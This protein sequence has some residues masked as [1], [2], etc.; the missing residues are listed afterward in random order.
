M[1]LAEWIEF[2]ANRIVR[3]GA[4]LSEEHRADYMRVQIEAALKKAFAH[5]RDR[6]TERDPPRAVSSSGAMGAAVGDKGMPARP[7]LPEIEAA[8]RVLTDA[9]LRHHW[10]D[11]YQTSYDE[12]AATDAIGKEEFD[13]IVEAMLMA[14]AAARS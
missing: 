8:A 12:L 1:D 5:G 14:A 9:G 4:Q 2:E 10:W 7:T 11:P 6:L 3:M 13:T